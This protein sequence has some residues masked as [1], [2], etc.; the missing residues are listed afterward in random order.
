[1]TP[2]AEEKENARQ[3]D[4]E[5]MEAWAEEETRRGRRPKIQGV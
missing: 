2:L 1:V 3:D 5:N 4:E